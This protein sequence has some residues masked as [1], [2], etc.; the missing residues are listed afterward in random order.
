MQTG[1][2]VRILL[3]DDH[4]IILDGISLML[5]GA[6]GIEICG[7]TTDAAAGLSLAGKIQPDIIIAD[8]SMPG[9]NGIT[10][11][12]RAAADLPNV[13]I[14]I[15]S[16]HTGEDYICSLVKAGVRGYLTKQS[17]SRQE[18]LHAIKVVMQGDT[19]FSS[20]VSKVIMQKYV[21]QVKPGHNTDIKPTALT[22]RE[23]D[24]IALYAD[25]LSNQ[26][27]AEKLCISVKTVDAHKNNIMQKFR[28]KSTVDMVKY[29]IRNNLS[30]L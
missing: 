25:G 2:I 28:F 1:I 27:I 13:K 6:P 10:L 17:T 18:I 9:M 3:I 7:T 11:A 24:I 29:A 20:D 23:K 14:L 21:Q 19:Y 12:E 26:E 22:P 30:D 16:M 4:Q 15:L 5:E 8:I